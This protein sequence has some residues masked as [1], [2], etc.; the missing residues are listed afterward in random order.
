MS[1]VNTLKD[2]SEDLSLEQEDS[3]ALGQTVEKTTRR[4]RGGALAAHR[5][6]TN[7]LLTKGLPETGRRKPNEILKY[8]KERD[9]TKFKN[10]SGNR[11]LDERNVVR[12]INAMERDGNMSAILCWEEN[13]HWLVIDGQHRV[14][15]C[16]RLGI[17]VQMLLARDPMNAA[18]IAL[19]NSRQKKWNT[20]NYLYAK[21][22]VHKDSAAN[23]IINEVESL[24]EQLETKFSPLCVWALLTG[25]EGLTSQLKKDKPLEIHKEAFALYNKLKPRFISILLAT[26][27]EA[28][29]TL[30]QVGV[31][32]AIHDL[33]LD[34][35][36]VVP[37][38]V[39]VLKEGKRPAL[40]N[41]ARKRNENLAVLLN[42]YCNNTGRGVDIKAK[43]S[44]RLGLVK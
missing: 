26:D 23:F 28:R 21:G 35:D 42:F 37:E 31:V 1:N 29:V 6:Q 4:V 27:L 36:F 38:M 16:K 2:F 13:G 11:R 44:E 17:P 18:Q 14:E 9:Y 19:Y 24:T 43:M 8:V 15:A 25:N 3:S 33:L 20:Q 12:L 10:V 30:K 22:E 40:M 41:G 34:P 7:K 32:Q 5:Q 39:R